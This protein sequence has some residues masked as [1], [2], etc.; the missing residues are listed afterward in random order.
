VHVDDGSGWENSRLEAG[1]VQMT[2]SKWKVRRT[3]CPSK[4]K[5]R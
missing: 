2:R 5:V 4:W 3:E 1:E